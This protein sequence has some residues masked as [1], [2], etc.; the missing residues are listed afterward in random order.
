MTKVGKEDQGGIFN[1]LDSF[2]NERTE[3]Y[4]NNTQRYQCV[5]R[6]TTLK[7]KTHKYI[8][9]PDPIIPICPQ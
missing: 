4:T 8:Q 5:P 7:I 2:K 1:L 6:S 9:T 3:P